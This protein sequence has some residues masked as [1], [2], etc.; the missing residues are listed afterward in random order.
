MEYD[1]AL[2]LLMII[3]P[4]IAEI[5]VQSTYNKYKNKK[6]NANL[7]GY[8]VA[9]KILD[10]NGL[11]NLY[12][13]ETQ[14][15]MTDNYDVTRK[16]IKL[17]SEVYH[18][19]SIASLAIAAHECGHAIQD[20][21]GYSFFKFRST[22]FP[23][24]NIGTRIA[25]IVLLIGFIFQL[26]DLVWVG[27]LL[28]G[29]GLIFELV[30]LPVEFNASN[31]ALENIQLMHLINDEGIDGTKQMLTS[32]ALTYVAAVLSTMFQMLRLIMA[33]TNKRD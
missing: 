1:S 2:W 25:W 21:N 32:A 3:I 16:T 33:F 26:I 24:V 18:G 28:V 22:I 14:G 7:T 13:V 29:L 4:L 19:S 15:T 5:Y 10:K 9:R 31:R 12:I 17:S 30:T 27:I 20:K 8:D 23:I 6:N 11:N